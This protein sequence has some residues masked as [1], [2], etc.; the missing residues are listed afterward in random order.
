MIQSVPTLI[1][2]TSFVILDPETKKTLLIYSGDSLIIGHI[3]MT[4][5][6]LSYQSALE[7]YS[8]EMVLFCYLDYV[9]MIGVSCT[10]T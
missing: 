10:E 5:Q 1:K 8:G 2:L 9:E 6:T 7:A 4:M 3:V